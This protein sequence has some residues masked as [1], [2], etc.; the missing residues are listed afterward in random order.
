MGDKPPLG[1]DEALY[2]RM[3]G[4]DPDEAAAEAES[5]LEKNSLGCYYS[6]VVLKALS[7]AESDI[8]R[9]ALD[10]ERALKITD[11]TR[12]LIQNLSQ[13]SRFDC[14]E[15]AE[16]STPVPSNNSQPVFC[17][18]GRGPADEAAALLLI[19]LLEQAGIN[20]QSI[21]AQDLRAPDQVGFSSAR[22]V[23]VCYLHSG[24]AIRA[25]YLLRRVRRL[26]PHAVHLAAFWD[27]NNSAEISRN[28]QCQTVGCFDDAITAIKAAIRPSTQS[29]S[30]PSNTHSRDLPLTV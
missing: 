29:V 21:S 14:V 17:V 1:V 28:L 8:N 23:C 6:E 2:L 3:L 9:G 5:F 27:A 10:S 7:L 24:N 15:G 18:G 4:E 12:N 19:H 11:T 25:A 22:V 20:A 13:S 30:A 26:A 16:P